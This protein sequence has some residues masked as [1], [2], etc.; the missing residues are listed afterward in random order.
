[1]KHA[2]EVWLWYMSVLKTIPPISLKY[3]RVGVEE[4]KEEVIAG[5]RKTGRKRTELIDSVTGDDI[6]C[7]GPGSIVEIEYEEK[8]PIYE[9]RV[10]RYDRYA[11]VNREEIE[12]WYHNLTYEQKLALN[13]AHY[14]GTE[15][16]SD[17][18]EDYTNELMVR[19]Q[20]IG[21]V[22]GGIYKITD[23]EVFIDEPIA[24]AEIYERVRDHIQEV[25]KHAE[26][27]NH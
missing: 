5:Y 18:E 12:E 13:C 22:E 8:E 3:K 27:R 23:E 4:V 14:Y 11:L 21:G 24:L 26:D 9:T 15:K 2:N 19:M 1:M 7:G 20:V 16:P 6:G 10:K 25:V 17:D